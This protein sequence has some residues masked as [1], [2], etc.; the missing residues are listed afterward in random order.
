MRDWLNARG[1][2]SQERAHLEPPDPPLAWLKCSACGGE[3]EYD[4]ML[5]RG[6]KPFCSKECMRYEKESTVDEN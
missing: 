2:A 1:M 6:D 4:D 5:W 3:K